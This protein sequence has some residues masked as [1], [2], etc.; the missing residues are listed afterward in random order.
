[1]NP[2][3]CL[4]IKNLWVDIMTHKGIANPVCNVSL[5]VEPGKILGIVGESGSGKSLT[6]R[7]VLRLLEEQAQNIQCRGEIWFQG[8]DLLKMSLASVRSLRGQEMS[9]IFQD[10]A[11][12]L[13]PVL[14]VGWQIAEVFRTHT[15]CSWK[16]A[17]EETLV[18]LK[19]MGF[20]E[21]TKIY[22]RFAFQLSGGMSQRVM[23]AMA[24]AL[25]PSLIIADEPTTALDVTL[26]A[27]VL[28]E[29]KRLQQEDGVSIILIS[30]DMGVIAEMA[31]TVIVM[32]HGKIVEYNDCMQLFDAPKHEYTRR[33][34]AASRFE[35]HPETKEH[36]SHV[37]S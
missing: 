30:H 7:A 25:K 22:R 28:S 8:R 16:K 13:N 4:E 9:M 26:Q 29:L 15:G 11:T 24:M 6:A 23:I 18:L 10:P 33:L 1:M 32:N 5:C 34:L 12:A 36:F 17:K 35:S 37:T 14:P 3:S 21:P 27:Q 31:D 20:H 2:A 19:K